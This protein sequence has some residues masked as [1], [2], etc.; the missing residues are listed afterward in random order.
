MNDKFYKKNAGKKSDFIN[1][2]SASKREKIV[3]L[4]A[5]KCG[6]IKM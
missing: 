4:K 2:T 5:T 3:A 6:Y 1:T